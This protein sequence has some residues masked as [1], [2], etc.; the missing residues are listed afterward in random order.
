MWRYF[1]KLEYFGV[2]KETCR[3]HQ[4]G[5]TGEPKAAKPLCALATASTTLLGGIRGVRQMPT[6]YAQEE[7]K[8]A[9]AFMHAFLE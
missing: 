2:I 6:W 4:R 7:V 3:F 5:Q 1:G 9:K 8:Y